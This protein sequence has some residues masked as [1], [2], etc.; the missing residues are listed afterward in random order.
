MYLISKSLKEKIASHKRPQSEILNDDFYWSNKL[1]K[2]ELD[3]L[4]KAYETSVK[5]RLYKKD[6]GVVVSNAINVVISY[7][8][9]WGLL[10]N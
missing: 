9:I 3:L 10:S 7:N 8:Y 5:V 1:T 4:S 2:A 6:L